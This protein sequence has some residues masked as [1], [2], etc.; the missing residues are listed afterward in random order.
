MSTVGI[1]SSVYVSAWAKEPTSR[2]ARRAKRESL[3]HV[4]IRGGGQNNR[5]LRI[6]HDF[7]LYWLKFGKL[8]WWT[9][10][11]YILWRNYQKYVPK[12]IL[13]TRFLNFQGN[14]RNFSKFYNKTEKIDKTI[15]GIVGIEQGRKEKPRS[16]RFAGVAGA[17]VILPQRTQRTQKSLK[18]CVL[19][20]LCVRFSGGL[21]TPARLRF[22]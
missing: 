19:C 8:G 7:S 14:R 18:L 20:E 2:N 15:K 21:R 6:S 17:E 13:Y 5:F 11:M 3:P 16:A 9:I 22:A 12:H 4:K 1:V 10:C